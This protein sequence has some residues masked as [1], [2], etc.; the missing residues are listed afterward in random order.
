MHD[1]HHGARG[2]F[3]HSFFSATTV[4]TRLFYTTYEART[5]RTASFILKKEGDGKRQWRNV[6]RKRTI[7]SV[8]PDSLLRVPIQFLA[9]NCVVSEVKKEEWNAKDRSVPMLKKETPFSEITSVHPSVFAPKKWT[10]RRQISDVSAIKEGAP[11]IVH[12]DGLLKSIQATTT[13]YRS[14]H[15]NYVY[16]HCPRME[17]FVR[18]KRLC[19]A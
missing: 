4:T 1:Y 6:R 15:E 12:N 9:S 7:F 5:A 17:C 8:Q 3:F 16:I 11:R 13:P 14:H 10:A 18:R 19:S 2:I